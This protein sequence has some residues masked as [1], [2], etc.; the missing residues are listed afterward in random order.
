M[1]FIVFICSMPLIYVSSNISGFRMKAEYAHIMDDRNALELRSKGLRAQAEQLNLDVH[2][3]EL[4]IL[5]VEEMKQFIQESFMME[6]IRVDRP[7]YY[8]IL[9]EKIESKRQLFEIE[10]ILEEMKVSVENTAEKEVQTKKLVALTKG[11]EY[12]EANYVPP[13]LKDVLYNEIY[14]A[15]L[16]CIE[17]GENIGYSIVPQDNIISQDRVKE[18]VAYVVQIVV[19]LLN[20]GFNAE[21]IARAWQLSDGRIV[22]VRF[23]Y[24]L[25]YKLWKDV[26]V[27]RE[28]KNACDAWV[29]IFVEPLE[30]AKKAIIARYSSRMSKIAREQGRIWGSHNPSVMQLAR[31]V[32]AEEY[33]AAY[34]SNP[35]EKAIGFLADT[36][37]AVDPEL[38]AMCECW[39]QMYP[40]EYKAARVLRDV[41]LVEKFEEKHGKDTACLLSYQLMNG[42]EEAK[43]FAS[44]MEAAERWRDSHMEAYLA[45]EREELEKYAALFASGRAKDIHIDAALVLENDEISKFI[46][47]RE[48]L[49]EIQ[50]TTEL[51]L[52]A[53]CWGQC[54]QGL[55]KA[56]FV[57]IRNENSAAFHRKWAELAGVSEDFQKGSYLYTDP[58]IRDDPAQDRFH[59]FRIRLKGKYDWALGYLLMTQQRCLKELEDLELVDP[60]YKVKFNV[61]PSEAVRH[62]R[63]T[64]RVFM[65]QKAVVEKALVESI[66][67]QSMWNSYF[68]VDKVEGEDVEKK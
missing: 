40:E 29:E 58:A 57:H 33:K 36:T 16:Q 47:D 54:N 42:F 66:S 61:R 5:K 9:E 55:L 35:G 22:T 13:V 32:L 19:Q 4:S 21:S 26:A 51:V 63:D 15:Q 12:Q 52:H 23:I 14:Y 24:V 46:T 11:L 48:T 68:G 18:I 59:G 50:Q 30:C 8:V 37:G 43:P 60:L 64:D 45:K 62:Q 31:V 6:K 25:C 2:D 56:G 28:E 38:R 39:I 3:L 20:D 53:K 49:A 10:T 67:K 44:D 1:V 41:E 34:T 7:D 27:D 17:Y 65:Q